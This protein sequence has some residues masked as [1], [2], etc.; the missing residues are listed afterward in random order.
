M[1]TIISESAKQKEQKVFED[2]FQSIDRTQS[3]KFS[4]G[5]GSGKTYALVECLKYVVSTQEKVLRST[6]QTVVCI[7]YTNVATKEIQKRLKDNDMVQISTI[8][9]RIW[10]FIC[11]YQKELILIHAE[12]LKSEIDKEMDKVLTSQPKAYNSL[13]SSIQSHIEEIVMGVAFMNKFWESFDLNSEP[14][15]LQI[16]GFFT[17]QISAI[18]LKNVSNFKKWISSLS[19]IQSYKKCLERIQNTRKGSLEVIYDVMSNRDHLDRM[20]IS[21][22]TLL[23]YG[24]K[25]ISTYPILAQIIVDQHPYFF[26]DEYQDTNPKVISIIRDLQKSAKANGHLFLVGLFGDPIQNIYDDGIGDVTDN[27]TD[28]PIKAIEKLYNRR[29]CKEIIDIANR[30]RG[31]SICQESIFDDCQGGSVKFFY[32]SRNYPDKEQ[33]TKQFIEDIKEELQIGNEGRIDCFVLT[34]KYL[35]NAEGIGELY[36]IFSSLP[37][38]K[39]NFDQLNTET[40]SNDLTKLGVFQRQLYNFVHFFIDLNS[41]NM[42]VSSLYY[43]EVLEGVTIKQLQ[44]IV[45]MSKDLYGDSLE[46]IFM[47]INDMVN[48]FKSDFSCERLIKQLT[49]LS[50]G[51]SLPPIEIVK[52][53]FEQ[54]IRQSD[55][56]LQMSDSE[57]NQLYTKL[58]K[59]DFRI[60]EK[61]V[62]YI[63]RSETSGIVYHT[64]HGTKGLEF[65]NVI[66]ILDRDFGKEKDFFTDFFKDKNDESDNVSCV[67][68]RNL[69]YV[70]VSRAIQ[71]LRVLFRDDISD[72]IGG[73]EKVFASCEDYNYERHQ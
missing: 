28:Y 3:F 47:N 66:I 18:L 12:K 63:D 53:F 64:Y 37:Y 41:S 6:G 25:M 23:E 57:E 24:Q 1:L 44:R 65:Q 59:L 9:E 68:A 15:K 35:A 60:L 16:S 11:K 46:K 49:I 50:S 69:L 61:W 33:M 42:F 73:V 32:S 55:S 45:Q 8:H 30:I 26:I 20:K 10:N 36:E 29:S 27:N 70:A 72:I 43:H 56:D 71:N 13:D 52:T 22:D 7:T 14:F 54:F 58:I 48:K 5:A 34:N 38:Y 2:L 31:D 21:H 19:R 51:N 62:R 17:E 67:K 4:A 40:L 39:R